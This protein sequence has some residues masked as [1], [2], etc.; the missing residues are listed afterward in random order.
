MG[1][2]GPSKIKEQR[3]REGC[4]ERMGTGQRTEACQKLRACV[5]VYVSESPCLSLS[6]RFRFIGKLCVCLIPG[7]WE[8]AGGEETGEER[9]GREGHP[10]PGPWLAQLHRPSGRGPG[11][12]ARAESDPCRLGRNGGRGRSKGRGEGGGRRGGQ[13]LSDAKGDVAHIEAPGLS[14]HL[15]PD[16]GHWRRGHRQT[17]WGHGGEEGSG[18]NLTRSFKRD[19]KH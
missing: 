18:W 17:I 14:G 16:H 13:Y 5:C 6:T 3:P 2:S 1:R 19:R 4:G 7:L 9:K 15:A 12:L 8:E 11:G 10:Q